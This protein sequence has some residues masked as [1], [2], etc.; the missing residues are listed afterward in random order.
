[1]KK[2]LIKHLE[3]QDK[4]SAHVEKTRPCYFLSSMVDDCLTKGRNMHGGGARYHDYGSSLI[5]IPNAADALIAIKKA[6]FD[7]KFCTAQ[8]LTL[9]LKANFEGYEALRKKLLALPKYGQEN[10]EADAVA[11]RLCAD[12]DEAYRSYVN[13]H[14]GNGKLVLLTFVWAP[15]AGG[16]LGASADGRLAGMPIAHSVTP[17]SSSMTKGITAAMNSC[18]SLPFELF[19]GGAS[20]MWDLDPSIATPK[21]VTALFTTFFEQGGH[22]FQGNVTD[23]GELLRAQKDPDK[24]THLM[25]RVGG[26]SARFVTLSTELQNEIITRMRHKC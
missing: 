5:G 25:V 21:I 16:L 1:M 8:E 15:V 22:I 12:L 19:S 4:L 23:I 14:G 11:A 20:A 18:T 7:E 6:V 24:Y 2:A 9:A 3:F 26:Y 10:A 13:R 17:Q